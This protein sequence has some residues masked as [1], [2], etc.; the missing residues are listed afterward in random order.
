LHVN[1]IAA[2]ALVL[3]SSLAFGQEIGKEITPDQANTPPPANNPPPSYD[4][5]Y[6]P[7][8][9]PP[10]APVEPKAAAAVEKVPGPRKGAVGIRAAMGGEGPTLGL[11]VMASES[12]AVTFDAG[13][14]VGFVKGD[15]G[16]NL[17]LGIDVHLGSDK[18]PI[19]PLF[20]LGARFG[21][22]QSTQAD[23]FTLGFEV[24]GGAEYWFTDFFAV[25][26]K[27]LLGL[28]INLKSGDLSL[29]TLTPGI[30]GTFYF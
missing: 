9:P 6:A 19:R 26:G 2:A 1:R 23:D 20:V 28:P 21:K 15:F 11:A 12:V 22:T 4:N 7:P 16:F 8:P 27:L 18:K 3:V 14:G 25:N 29:V 10:T 30:G 17:G 5:P 24:G 13:L